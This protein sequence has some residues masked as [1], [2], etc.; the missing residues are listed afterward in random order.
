MFGWRFDVEQFLQIFARLIRRLNLACLAVGSTYS[1][2]AFQSVNFRLNLACLAV[3]ST[4]RRRAGDVRVHTRLNLACLAVGST[5]DVEAKVDASGYPP[6]SSLFGCRFDRHLRGSCKYKAPPQS[7][8]FGCRFD[9]SRQ[10][11]QFYPERRLNLACL[12][13]GSTV[14][15]HRA[16]AGVARLNLACLAVGSTESFRYR[17]NLRH[18]ASI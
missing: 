10:L 6:Q 15:R 3:G 17:A 14:F 9:V 2:A 8:L 16:D 5:S 1:G 11:H 18:S 12:A 4:D 7:S 13:V